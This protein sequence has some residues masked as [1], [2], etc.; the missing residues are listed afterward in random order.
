MHFILVFLPD[1]ITGTDDL[2]FPVKHKEAAVMENVC[3]KSLRF[4]S[5]LF[6]DISLVP[7]A[8]FSFFHITHMHQYPHTLGH[9][10]AFF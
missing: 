1:D 8:D 3:R 10:S 4:I 7:L 9:G 2:F 5:P 6:S